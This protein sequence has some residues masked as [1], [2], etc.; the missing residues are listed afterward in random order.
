ML[1]KKLAFAIWSLP[2]KNDWEGI[3]QNDSEVEK[4]GISNIK[5]VK[6]FITAPFDFNGEVNFIRPD[7]NFNSKSFS[8]NSDLEEDKIV[9]IPVKE[10]YIIDR[11]EYLESCGSLI[12]AI[13]RG[14]AEKVVY[15]RV[16]SVPFDLKK[17]ICFYNKLVEEHISA[18]V[19][20]Y[21]ID[22]DLWIGASP[23]IIIESDGVSFKSM[24][25]AGSKLAE[26]KSDW[27]E[28][29]IV[30]Q[31]FVSDYIENELIKHKVEYKKS[32]VKTIEAGPVAHLKTEFTGSFNNVEVSDIINAL[33]PTSAVCGIPKSDS[34]Q[35]I[36][37][38]EKHKRL[39]YTGFFGPVDMGKYNLFV[40]LRSALISENRMQIF[41]G[42]GL[43]KDS[44]PEDEWNETVLKS[45]TLLLSYKKC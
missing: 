3:A 34:K 33:H 6:G 1:H 37:T 43:T 19:F 12:N 27:G 30:E 14:A 21:F 26:D 22:G 11:E 42:G 45:K 24:A 17:L 9:E 15:S 10:T 44:I 28:K 20:M 13:K 31:E 2:G 35:L 25:L 7:I 29:E 23:E 40:N 18:M 41:V 38:T 32:E 36:L 8:L 16:I 5:L 39:D 4:I